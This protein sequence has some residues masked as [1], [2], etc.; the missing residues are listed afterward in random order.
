[1]IRHCFA[2]LLAGVAA[3]VLPWE[4]R[5]DD[6][7]E[8]ASQRCLV[9]GA[10]TAWTCALSF[11]ADMRQARLRSSFPAPSVPTRGL[12]VAMNVFGKHDFSERL[13]LII[14]TDFLAERAWRQQQRDLKTSVVQTSEA[15]FAQGDSDTRLGLNEL[16]IVSELS[17][18]WQMS[19]G[20]KR[21]IWGTGFASNPTDVLNPG[22]NL[23]DPATEKRGSW[24]IQLE[25][26]RDESTFSLFAAPG[27]Q[28]N[29]NSIPTDVL[30]YAESQDASSAHYLVGLRGYFLLGQTDLNVMLFHSERYKD[31]I[32]HQWK[33]GVSWSQSL[34]RLSD[35]LTGF[36][37]LL[38]QQGSSRLDS[39]F[40]SRANDARWFH[41][42]LLG[43]RY[44]FANES[45]LTV[46][47]FRQSD[48]DNR[49]DFEKR[50][51]NAVVGLRSQP[52]TTGSIPGVFAEQESGINSRT[53][54]TASALSL[55]NYLFLNY[56]RYKVT[57]DLLLSW[58][59]LHNLHDSSGSTGPS[60][61]W[62]PRESIQITFN[63]N[64][65]I[66]WAP[67]AAVSVPFLGRVK[68]S[69]LNPVKLRASLDVKSF[70]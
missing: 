60:I 13:R 4:S 63:A 2:L 48:G 61:V 25:H 34:N 32:S 24:L 17:P 3:A 31:D 66:S 70:F 59:M 62:S 19:A 15:A 68:E 45:A 8:I 52:V 28:E 42:V 18:A 67:E 64:T 7:S 51:K 9:F 1:M 10:E 65:D 53:T 57:D 46:E 22:K 23:L 35:S 44:D 36:G 39:S 6:S 14:D 50:L 47:L 69:D 33:G 30:N 58:S 41:K 11:R 56:Q 29:K 16:Y 43:A 37:E 49:A 26:V 12:S 38:L 20:K 27:V 55:Q 40:V 21:L 54:R 5:A